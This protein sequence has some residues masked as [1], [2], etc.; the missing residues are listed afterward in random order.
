MQ[1]LV[2]HISEAQMSA[3]NAKHQLEK[4]DTKIVAEELLRQALPKGV[5]ENAESAP[6]HGVKWDKLKDNLFTHLTLVC[7]SLSFA[8]CIGV[9]LG[10]LAGSS[11]LFANLT[12]SGTALLQTVPSLALLAFLVP[13]FGIGP[14]AAVIALLV[15]S[16]LPIVRNTYTGLTTIPGN[17]S[18]AA[19][20]IGLSPMAQLFQVRLPMASPAILAGIKTSAVINVGTATLAALVGAGGL[21]TS[22]L[23][24]I[25]LLDESLVLQGAIPAA[26]LTLLVQGFFDLVD[27]LVVPKGLRL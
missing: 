20:A 7:I 18:E 23:Q 24:G 11:R 25:A 3:A 26:I 4:V 21:G 9:P 5:A 22:I 17:L 8:I 1:Q 13:I 16:L 15:Y 10:V 6:A 12:L 2:G 14:R 19:E 27:R